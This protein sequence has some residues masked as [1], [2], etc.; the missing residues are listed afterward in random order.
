ME[1][2]TFVMMTFESGCGVR[3]AGGGEVAPFGRKF[4]YMGLRP[5]TGVNGVVREE[6]GIGD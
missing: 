6:L 4:I 1:I 5:S 3:G 2:E